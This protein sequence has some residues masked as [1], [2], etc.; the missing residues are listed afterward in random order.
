[1]TPASRSSV[2]STRAKAELALA[3]APPV[4][5]AVARAWLNRAQGLSDPLRTMEH[6]QA[7][8]LRFLDAGFWSGL[9]AAYWNRINPP[10]ATGLPVIA[11]LGL[12]G[13]SVRLSL[14]LSILLYFGVFCFFVARILSLE[15]KGYSWILATWAACMM[16]EVLHYAE[17]PWTELALMAALAAFAW[18]QLRAD[19]FGDG[20]HAFAAGTWLGL[21]MNARPIEGAL[22]SLPLVAWSLKRGFRNRVIQRRDLQGVALLLACTVLVFAWRYFH[23]AQGPLEAC[24]CLLAE[25]LVVVPWL[26]RRR[27]ALSPA[28]WGFLV[29]AFTLPLLWYGPDF[30]ELK[31]WILFAGF[32]NPSLSRAGSIGTGPAWYLKIVLGRYLDLPFAFLAAG[33]ALSAIPRRGSSAILPAA[34]F[35]VP[36][37]LTIVAASFAYVPDA[38]FQAPGVALAC[39]FLSARAFGRKGSIV[40]VR[41]KILSAGAILLLL[42]PLSVRRKVPGFVYTQLD[43]EDAVVPAY[44]EVTRWLPPQSPGQACEVL[45][46]ED[47]NTPTPSPRMNRW[48]P[49]VAAELHAREHGG[50]TLRY[51]H[52]KNATLEE[53]LRQ[54]A[55]LCPYVLVSPLDL[56]PSPE[57]AAHLGA[58]FLELW[59][60]QRLEQYGF[61]FLGQGEITAPDGHPTGYAWFASIDERKSPPPK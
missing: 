22:L 29:P 12:T 33:A 24:A 6:A 59:R 16:P 51:L 10:S 31:R 1:M 47:G 39:I 25:A 55:H 27:L 36:V 20:T 40:D 53:D 37:G 21:A 18:H 13:G 54:A 15:L 43:L 30:E 50:W 9:H 2:S 41:V 19:G 52:L 4:L 11:L 35:L 3:A 7:C 8:Y 45:V 23:P 14:V 58:K 28:L 57:G 32:E 56:P 48:F 46:P 44:R 38:R 34:P 17:L 5:I 26:L 42:V 49:A 60:G 61:R